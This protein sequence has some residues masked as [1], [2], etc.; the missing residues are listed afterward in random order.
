MAEATE[1]STHVDADPAAVLEVIADLESYPGWVDG[2]KSVEVLETD[3]ERPTQARFVVDN[4]P[5][6]DTYV[7]D[8]T[9]D[10]EDSGVG[11]VSWTLVEARTITR[12]DGAYELAAAGT[13]TEV[14]YRLTVEVTVKLPGIIRRRA[15]KTVVETALKGLRRRVEA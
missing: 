2:V 4:G 14:S 9:W 11:T 8:Y 12:L 1:S 13:G 6:K 5:I 3:G 10:V 7:L 15:E